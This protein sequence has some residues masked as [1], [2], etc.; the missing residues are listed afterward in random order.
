MGTEAKIILWNRLKQGAGGRGGSPRSPC[1]R[2]PGGVTPTGP[3]L[4]WVG[5]QAWRGEGAR[6]RSQGCGEKVE[7]PGGPCKP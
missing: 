7:E 5:K 1:W 6:P 2:G 3:L 4:L